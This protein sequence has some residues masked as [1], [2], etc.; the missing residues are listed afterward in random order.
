MILQSIK[1][2][3]E[4]ISA[5]RIRSFLTMLGIIIG[6]IALVVLVSL[7]SSTSEAITDEV[8]SL[9]TNIFTVMIRDD[10]GNPLRQKD[11]NTFLENDMVGAI[12]PL[13]QALMKARHGYQE[14]D[15]TVYG[16]LPSYGEIHG[17]KLEAGRFLRTTDV[18]N[19]TYVTVLSKEA[20]EKLV[21]SSNAVGEYIQLNGRS[22]L[23]VGVLAED[24]SLMNAIT[25]SIKIYV[26]YPVLSRMSNQAMGIRTII[27]APTNALDMQAAEESLNALLLQRFKQDKDAFWVFNQ[28][29]L[30]DSLSTITNALS[31]LLGGIAA[32]SLLVGGIGIMNIMLVSVTER[33]K[34]IGIRKAIGAAKGSI[35]FQF[36][37]EALVVSLWGCLIGIGLSFAILRVATIVAGGLLSFSL[38]FG[39]VGIAV[40]F[41]VAIGVIFGIYPAYKAANMM[42]VEALRYEG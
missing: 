6:V 13:G 25:T 33:T 42:P 14:E 40:A 10:K 34:E 37:V 24:K 2:A 27:V 38:S 3:F 16:M 15:A 23:V 17:W 7:V 32:I 31:I 19:S 29:S 21:G 39:V 8:S 11:L 1:M 30:M 41:S 4:S 28:S 9:G 12:S 26:P 20:S 22:F 18:E 35:L 36:L 5:N